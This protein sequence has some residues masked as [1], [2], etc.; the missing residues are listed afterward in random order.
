MLKN[1]I[2][3][4]LMSTLLLSARV[5]SS[6]WVAVHAGKYAEDWD[7]YVDKQSAKKHASIARVL[8][9]KD[10]KTMQVVNNRSYFSSVTEMEYDCA[11]GG[12]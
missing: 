5:E 9:L 8:V 10:F 7:V 11:I 1:Y 6:E 4:I 12:S 2:K 3:I